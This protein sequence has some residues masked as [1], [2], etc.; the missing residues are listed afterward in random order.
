MERIY[1]TTESQRAA[2]L[3]YFGTP[4]GKEAQRRYYTS[5]KGRAA[6]N[7]RRNSIAGK[8]NEKRYRDSDKGRETRRN[9]ELAHP[10]SYRRHTSRKVRFTLEV[11][12]DVEKDNGIVRVSSSMFPELQVS[13]NSIIHAL[14]LAKLA[15]ETHIKALFMGEGPGNTVATV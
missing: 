15:S 14:A 6:R 3:R 1:K 2:S 8:A 9:Y 7:Q 11:P 5:E 12:L 13:A 10:Y 4:A